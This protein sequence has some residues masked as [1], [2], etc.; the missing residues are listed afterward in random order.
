MRF[1]KE[2]I[3]LNCNELSPAHGCAGLGVGELEIRAME[4]FFFPKFF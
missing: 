3:K 4:G 1:A 2:I